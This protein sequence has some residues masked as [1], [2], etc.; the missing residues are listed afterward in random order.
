ML[1]HP[2]VGFFF[3]IPSPCAWQLNYPLKAVGN[4]RKDCRHH[5]RL[6]SWQRLDKPALPFFFLIMEA[7]T[8]ERN[9]CHDCQI[10][11]LNCLFNSLYVGRRWDQC[12]AVTEQ[13]DTLVFMLLIKL[14][15]MVMKEPVIS[16]ILVSTKEWC[17]TQGRSRRIS[18]LC[19]CLVLYFSSPPIGKISHHRS[20]SLVHSPSMSLSSRLS[21]FSQ[22][23]RGRQTTKMPK[24][25]Y[26][27]TSWRVVSRLSIP[28]IC[29]ETPNSDR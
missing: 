20:S 11:K 6:G 4:I 15:D 7:V 17:L 9:C 10:L 25:Q 18:S 5:Y 28:A 19:S 29:C 24:S 26:A 27:L 8:K 3:V 14:K 16:P 2:C 12:L 21:A 22:H 13:R 23:R 1:W